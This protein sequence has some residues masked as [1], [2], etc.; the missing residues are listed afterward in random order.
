MFPKRSV[1]V[2][3]ELNL[4]NLVHAGDEAHTQGIHFGFETLGR[5]NQKSKTGISV[6]TKDLCPP[7]FYFKNDLRPPKY[8]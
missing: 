6:A 3:S 8:I 5:C 4:R 2:A 1:G 7:N